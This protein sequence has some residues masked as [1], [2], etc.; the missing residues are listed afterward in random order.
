MGR[1]RLFLSGVA[2]G[3]RRHGTVWFPF[4]PLDEPADIRVGFQGLERVVLSLELLVVEDD[5]LAVAIPAVRR[6]VAERHPA[7]LGRV[8]VARPDGARVDA[9]GETGARLKRRAYLEMQMLVLALHGRG[10]ARVASVGDDLALIHRLDYAAP[11]LELQKQIAELRQWL[12]SAVQLPL[13]A[14]GAS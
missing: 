1:R 5:V 3:S 9:I 4:D 13:A 2:L 7:G 14:L 11:V 10:I 6:E 8:E 12:S